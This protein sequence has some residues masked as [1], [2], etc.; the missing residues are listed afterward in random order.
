[1]KYIVVLG[2]GMAD[3]KIERLDNKTPLEYAETPNIDA[4]AKQS[5]IGLCRTVPQELKPGSDVANLSVLGYDPRTCYTGRSPLEAVSM[6]VTLKDTD[7]TMR[8]NLV[9]LSDEENFEDKH[10]IDYSAGEISTEEAHVLIEYL[11][12]HLQ[13]DGLS[14]HA[15]ISYRHLLVMEHGKTGNELTPPHDITG[16]PVRGHLPQGPAAETLLGVM[17]LAAKLLKGHPVNHAR[18][19]AGKKPANAVWFWGEGTRPKLENFES[20]FGVKGAIISAVDLIKGIGL[21]SGMRVL[22]VDGATGNYDTNFAGKA[23]AA[24]DAL[25]DADLVYIHMEAPDEC[26]HQGDVEHKVY[27]IEQIDSKVVGPIVNR[28]RE[29]GEPFNL[30][31]CPDHPTPIAV[32]THVSDPVPYL[33][34]RCGGKGCGAQRYD[35]DSAKSTGIFVENGYELMQ[36][37]LDK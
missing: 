36:K 31:L 22:N 20:K 26:G 21:L 35:E 24:L 7:V 33:L 5:E 15:G 12:Q 25:K 19:A 9:T 23:N 1:M 14:L 18:I 17:K 32:R 11:A 4:L 34:Y 6:G 30:L 3:Y 27:S 13:G 16:K 8:C 37:L 10:M 2:D 29:Q 28:L